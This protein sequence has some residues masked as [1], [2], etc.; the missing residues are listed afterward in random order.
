MGGL[1]ARTTATGWADGRTRADGV[2]E[3]Q[4]G[5][6]TCQLTWPSEIQRVRPRVNVK[7]GHSP[8]PSR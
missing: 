2:V 4:I 8:L 7:T 1:V 3:E 5:G 6:Q